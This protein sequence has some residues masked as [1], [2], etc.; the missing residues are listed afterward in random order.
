MAIAAISMVL[1]CIGSVSASDEIQEGNITAIDNSQDIVIDEVSQSDDSL[2]EETVGATSDDEILGDSMTLS[3]AEG[4]TTPNVGDTVKFKISTEPGNYLYSYDT[5]KVYIREGTQDNYKSLGEVTYRQAINGEASYTFEQSGTYNIFLCVFTNGPNYYSNSIEF[6]VGEGSGSGGSET[7]TAEYPD[8]SNGSEL[9]EY[10]IRIFDVDGEK[11]VDVKYVDSYGSQSYATVDLATMIYAANGQTT[12]PSTVYPGYASSTRVVYNDDGTN[13]DNYQY[14]KYLTTDGTDYSSWSSYT[15]GNYVYEFAFDDGVHRAY[16]YY[17]YNGV[18]YYSNVFYAY[19]ADI[20]QKT[21]TP[22]LRLYDKNN[23]AN[24]TLHYQLGDNV[25]IVNS[26]SDSVFGSDISKHIYTRT[27]DGKEYILENLDIYLNGEL[28]YSHGVGSLYSQKGDGILVNPND[29]TANGFNLYLDHEGWYNLTAKYYG[30]TLGL[31]EATSELLSIY[32]GSEMP[33]TPTK[34][35]VNINTEVSSYY[36]EDG[37]YYNQYNDIM[38]FTTTS[39]SDISGEIIYKEGDVE[40][41]RADLGEEFDISNLARGTHTITAYWAGNDDYNPAEYTFNVEII[42][43]D[44]YYELNI[45]DVVYPDHAVASFSSNVMGNY[46]ITINGKEYVVNYDDEYGESVEFDIDQLPVGTYEVSDVVFEDMENYQIDFENEDYNDLPSFEVFDKIPTVIW[47]TIEEPSTVK[48]GESITISVSVENGLTEEEITAGNVLIYDDNGDIATIDLTETDTYVFTPSYSA[49]ED[50]YTVYVKYLGNEEYGESDVD[51]DYY[52]LE[53]AQLDTTVS[54]QLNTTGLTYPGVILITPKVVDS[55]GNDVEVGIVRIYNTLY[56]TYAD[57]IATVNAGE[58]LNYTIPDNYPGTQVT[59]YAVYA[60]GESDDATYNPSE[61]SSGVTYTI[62]AS[63]KLDL[64]VNGATEITVDEG[65][66]FDV[67][68]TLTGGDG[69]ITLYINDEAYVKLTKGSETQMT[70]PVGDYTLYANY[71]RGSDIYD[72]AISNAVTVHV[73]ENV[74]NEIKVTVES[75]TLPDQ[76]EIKVTATLDGKYTIDVNGTE[77]NVTVNGGE[78]SELVTLAAGDYYANVTGQEGAIITNAVFT[79]LPQPTIGE[80]TIRDAKYPENA[81]I[82]LV[83]KGNV[84]IS[85]EYLVK[86][87][88]ENP[89]I[90]QIIFNVGGNTKYVDNPTYEQYAGAFNVVINETG[91]FTINATYHVWGLMDGEYYVQSN[92]L[93]YSV[94]ILPPAKD[95]TLNV[96]VD[97]EYDEDDYYSLEW[98]APAFEVVTSASEDIDA[99]IIYK[100]GDN[101]LGRA[102]VGEVFEIDPM[103]LGLGEHTIIATL[104]GSE[105]YNE[106]NYTFTLNVEKKIIWYKLQIDNVTYPDHAVGKFYSDVDGKYTISING[107]E[108]VVDF[109]WTDVD[110]PVSFDIKQLPVGT[111]TPSS[112]SFEDN[113]H[114]VFGESER[115]GQN[116]LPTFAVMEDVVLDDTVLTVSNGT[117]PVFSI[118][119]PGA[120]G[121]LTVTVD[122]K[123]YT[124]ELVDGKATVEITDLASGN[125]T[126]TVTYTGDETHKATSV[127]ASFKVEDNQTPDAS[128]ALDVNVPEGSTN[129][130][131]SINLPGAT[132]N[133]TVTV[134]GK[135]YTKELVNG[136]ATIVIDDL[137]PGNHNVT[138]RYS[139]DG[140]HSPISKDTTVSIPTPVL[141]NNKNINVVYS[142]NA[143]YS[144]RVTANG[145]AVAGEK[146][147][148]KFNGRNYQVTTNANGYATLKLN[149]KIKPKKY[150]ITAEFKGVKV[151]NTVTVKHLFKV[152][153]LKAK[154]SKKVLKI[155]IKTYKVNGKFLKGKKL[156]LKLK[157]K[158]LKAKINKKGVATFKVKKNILKKLKVGKKYKYT[159]SYGKDKLTKKITVR[160]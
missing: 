4:S 58:S 154:K 148:I 131:F 78:G 73:V 42:V 145:K 81:T 29:D 104:K 98:G 85:L 22:T 1:I 137:A 126:A 143:V 136:S 122:G 20:T 54:L 134:D 2:K 99:E 135:N 51:E 37:V 68:A 76:A 65:A 35:D 33:V 87:I 67:L 144:V 160:R 106:A 140:K 74:Q 62:L 92:V 80:L 72:S 149:T 97:E 27:V 146:V 32:V 43:K 101:E 14:Y 44:I 46:T 24:T 153:N 86:E 56:Y 40:L 152:K 109:E 105:D 7:S 6:V 49:K 31:G 36:D 79:V 71:T 5:D 127:P 18:T 124:K 69:E 91:D 94:T 158:V 128:K 157:G 139:G 25:S 117:T 64:K 66:T 8:G 84:T 3:L 30:N 100:E 95:I 13:Q 138:V 77:V 34:E 151:S 9:P 96:E 102:K 125:Y 107:E 119:L 60:G 132:G 16:S 112:I 156:K 48:K 110:E 113:E 103:D 129:P 120:S 70:L 15:R 83:G 159:V 75:V 118:D 115:E 63:N 141:S 11:F 26:L 133:L 28:L 150:T 123:N 57:A 147:T 53:A 38:T 89:Q 82:T 55:N 121:N 45:D 93:T 17:T 61:I 12:F 108:Y 52:Y 41:G 59:L 50:A 130:V 116:K 88:L 23:P 155:K 47:I 10:Y 39:Q 19:G 114:Y 21:S 142:G 111:Y 90:N